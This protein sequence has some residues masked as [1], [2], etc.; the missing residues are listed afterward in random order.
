MGDTKSSPAKPK[1]A[2]LE[3]GGIEAN[4]AGRDAIM[5]ACHVLDFLE[6]DYQPPPDASAASRAYFDRDLEAILRVREMVE[7]CRAREAEARIEASRRR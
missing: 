1:L 5:G 4:D 2:R 7:A 3:W 6:V